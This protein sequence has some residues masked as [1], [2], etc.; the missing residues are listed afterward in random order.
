M[1]AA[2]PDI[3][4]LLACGSPGGIGDP[5]VWVDESALAGASSC[6]RSHGVVGMVGAV[7]RVPQEA[8]VPAVYEIISR[9]WSTAN[10][11]RPYYVLRWPD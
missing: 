8:G 9:R 7:V 4:V 10:L 6:N 5:E 11:G 3:A 2:I 1:T